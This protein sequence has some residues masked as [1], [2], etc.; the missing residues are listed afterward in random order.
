MLRTSAPKSFAKSA[1]YVAKIRF[2]GLPLQPGT[3]RRDIS[4]DFHDEAASILLIVE[5]GLFRLFLAP[6]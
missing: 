1:L 6:L 2:C 5:Y 3:K 4:S